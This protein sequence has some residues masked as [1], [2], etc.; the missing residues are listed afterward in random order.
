MKITIE[1]PDFEIWGNTDDTPTSFIAELRNEI[2]SE[3]VRQVMEK[4]DNAVK[5]VKAD[6]DAALVAHM[7][8]MNKKIEIVV[9]DFKSK[10]EQMIDDLKRNKP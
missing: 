3:V 2:M 8:L 5:Q 10:A 9:A 6:C 7:S 1:I 4:S